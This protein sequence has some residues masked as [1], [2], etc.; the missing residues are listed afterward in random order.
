V[1][2]RLVPR[3]AAAVETVG[4]QDRN[5]SK[6]CYGNPCID[7]PSQEGLQS[8]H[9]TDTLLPAMLHPAC[10]QEIAA[11]DLP[12]VPELSQLPAP[13]ESPQVTSVGA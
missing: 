12:G 8:D 6:G 3:P 11:Y 4:N 7:C 13:A 5:G 2:L 1:T 9:E 10:R